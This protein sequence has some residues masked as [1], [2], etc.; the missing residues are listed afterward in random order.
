MPPQRLTSWQVQQICETTLLS[1]ILCYLQFYVVS[2]HVNDML[3]PCA[4]VKALLWLHC[5]A[6]LLG[7]VCPVSKGFWFYRIHVTAAA[8]L[9]HFRSCSCLRHIP[10]IVLRH[11]CSSNLSSC[12]HMLHAV[13]LLEWPSRDTDT[14]FR[15]HCDRQHHDSRRVWV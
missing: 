14:A 13:H 5:L 1:P 10:E 12:S 2:G 7:N 11:W 9:L 4:S 6:A 8:L 3:Q 15:G